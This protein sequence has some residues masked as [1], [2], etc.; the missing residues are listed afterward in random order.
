MT[1]K[2]LCLDHMT[3]VMEQHMHATTSMKGKIA[4]LHRSTVRVNSPV[5]M[6]SR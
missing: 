2:H 1:M 4:L 5:K 3:S 6:F